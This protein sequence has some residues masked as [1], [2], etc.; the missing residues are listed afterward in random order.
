MI[1]HSAYKGDDRTTGWTDTARM[2]SIRV[3]NDGDDKG[4][5]ENLWN[6]NDFKPHR[7]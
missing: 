1:N 7:Q 2:I 3:A 4:F 6:N 5:L